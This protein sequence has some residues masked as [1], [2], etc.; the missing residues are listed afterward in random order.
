MAL[1]RDIDI[2]PEQR[3]TLVA[4]LSRHLPNTE[5]W[6]YGSRITGSSHPGSDLDMVVFAAP[7]QARAV[8]ELRES[9]EESQLP[10]RVDLFMWDEVP[11]SF[12]TQIERGHV[13]LRG[14]AGEQGKPRGAT[15]G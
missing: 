9:C 6:V 10:F 7:G 11:E 1:N 13:V 5:A 2:T 3:E 14:A 12:R 4:L 15:H 8:S